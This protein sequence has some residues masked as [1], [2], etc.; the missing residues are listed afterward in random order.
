[1]AAASSRNSLSA[2]GGHGRRRT[3]R[4]RLHTCHGRRPQGRRPAATPLLVAATAVACHCRRLRRRVTGHTVRSSG[5]P[6][7]VPR[8]Q[9]LEPKR[10]HG[11][12]EIGEGFSRSP[13]LA[14]VGA[15]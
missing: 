6:A 11:P 3:P 15:S 12:S 10:I 13:G 7:Q 9:H 2:G 1:M 4:R 14:S 5:H 8:V